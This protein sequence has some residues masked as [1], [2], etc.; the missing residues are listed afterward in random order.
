MAGARTH[1]VGGVRAGFLILALY[2]LLTQAF[3]AGV[4]GGAHARGPDALGAH[5]ICLSQEGEAAPSSPTRPSHG[6]DCACPTL[7]QAAGLPALAL[8]PSFAAAPVRETLPPD[9][10]HVEPHPALRR[11]PAR[12]PPH[13][14]ALV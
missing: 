2:A 9:A 12:A 1:E 10:L 13:D 6:H 7:C 8:A 11:P 14:S 5:P 4:M 3:L